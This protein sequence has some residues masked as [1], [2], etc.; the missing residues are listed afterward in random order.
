MNKE[1][2]RT[3]LAE[4]V[5]EQAKRAGASA[6]S[7]RINSRR[8]VE[9]E[10]REGQIDKL[11]EAMASGLSLEL[12]VDGRY[13]VHSTQKMDETSL[14][15]FV[16]DGVALTRYLSEDTFRRLPE[17]ALTRFS[18]EG[19]LQTS[20]VAY[21]KLETTRRIELAK[22]AEVAAR[23]A[24]GSTRISTSA[25]WSDVRSVVSAFN[26]AGF[27]GEMAGTS[28]NI[29]ADVTVKDGDKGRPEGGSYSSARHLEDL[30][31][32][33]ELGRD[34]AS[35]ALAKVGQ[36]KQ[37]T[38]TY[39]IVVENRVANQLL[40]GMLQSMTAWAIQQKNSFLDGRLGQKIGSDKL[41][42][43]DDP[44]LPRGLG[45]MRFDNENLAVKKRALIEGGTLKTFL[46]D[47]YFGKKLGMAPNGGRTSNLIL[48][49]GSGDLLTLTKALGKGII[50]NGW[51]GGNFNGT[52]G[53]FSYGI[54]GQL[55]E[56]GGV[57]KAVNE[58]NL[59]GN[60]IDLWGRLDRVGG[61]PNINSGWRMPSLLF[62]G[63]QL[64]GA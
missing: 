23:E 29:G 7:L 1:M 59:T 4:F 53:D 25:G 37:P 16:Q 17:P 63:L 46:I 35:R 52:T 42:L 24:S 22:A 49:G 20:D 13:S 43:I 56:N 6:C 38:G 39:D 58:M 10:V 2:N 28:F 9:V 21:E 8:T 15:S 50:I 32:P 45:S 54:I 55:V 27:R 36:A 12:Y 61:D 34:A 14:K 11:Q 31:K 30:L 40:E 57:V 48:P 3:A 64:S 44:F 33:D 47:T 41:T 26:S 60:F 18:T 19:D 62:R 51:I 5:M